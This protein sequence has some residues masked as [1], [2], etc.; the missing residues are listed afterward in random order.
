MGAMRADWEQLRRQRFAEEDVMDEEQ[1]EG[2]IERLARRVLRLDA[3]A[4]IPKTFGGFRDE[5]DLQARLEALAAELRDVGEEASQR[6]AAWRVYQ[7]CE[8]E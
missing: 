1:Q 7:R 5:E 2:A 3:D 6:Q 4:P 8:S